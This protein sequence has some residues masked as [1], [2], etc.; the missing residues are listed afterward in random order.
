M[1]EAELEHPAVPMPPQLEADFVAN[2][3]PLYAPQSGEVPP[4][5]L[6][7]NRVA[8]LQCPVMEP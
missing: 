4:R 1:V 3:S 8:L 5:L 2:D 6:T 7:Q